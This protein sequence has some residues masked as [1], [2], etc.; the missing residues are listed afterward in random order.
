MSDEQ[1]NNFKKKAVS[2]IPFD[3]LLSME[4]QTAIQAD[5]LKRLQEKVIKH[6]PALHANPSSIIP[7]VP[8]EE[9]LPGTPSSIPAPMPTPIQQPT[10]LSYAIN[11]HVVQVPANDE[12]GAAIMLFYTLLAFVW[13]KDKNVAKILKQFD[14]KFFDANKKQVYPPVNAKTKK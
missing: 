13:G 12:H 9:R 3:V 11:G 2:H 4:K 8:V 6:G 10:M 5:D 7:N 1:P 14:F